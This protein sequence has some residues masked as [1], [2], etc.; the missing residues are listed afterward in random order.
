MFIEYH[1]IAG[2]YPIGSM[3]AIYG[4]IYHQYIPF[5]L[6]YIPYM[7]PSWDR[8]VGF[9]RLL[10]SKTH[11]FSMACPFHLG[12][13]TELAQLRQEIATERLERQD[14]ARLVDSLVKDHGV[15]QWDHGTMGCRFM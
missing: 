7:D 12:I 13:E 5:M 8:I 14:L 11:R 2:F 4:N 15:G 6:A 3:Y 1:R 10:Q 9:Y